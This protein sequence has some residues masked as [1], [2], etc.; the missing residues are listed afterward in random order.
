MVEFGA[1]MLLF[2]PLR[3]AVLKSFLPNGSSQLGPPLRTIGL[4][5]ISISSKERTGK[6]QETKLIE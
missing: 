2:E 1:G 6:T 4:I 3:L 5:S